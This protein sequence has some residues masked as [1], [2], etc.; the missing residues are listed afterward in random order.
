MENFK[1]VYR[2]EAGELLLEL[3]SSLLE[4]EKYPTDKELIGKVFRAMHTIKGSGA[5]FGFTDIAAFTHDLETVFDLVRND[6]MSVG[7]ELIGLVLAACDHIRSLLEAAFTEKPADGE[8]GK[9][10][11]DALRKL[12]PVIDKPPNLKSLDTLQKISDEPEQDSESNLATFRIFF[13]P[14]RNIF[15][16]GTNPLSLF[17]ELANFGKC[18]I[19]AHPEGIPALD[20]INPEECYTCWDIILTTS[21]D[22]NDIKDVFIFIEDMSELQV[23][24]LYNSGPLPDAA[25]HEIIPILKTTS[26]LASIFLKD[27][28]QKYQPVIST[29]P[30]SIILQKPEEKLQPA[31]TNSEKVKTTSIR[32]ASEKLDTLVDLVGEFVTVQARLAQFAHRTREIDAV[33]ISEQVEL[34]TSELRD[35]VMSLRML[36]IGTMF[37]KFRRLVRDLSVELGKDVE[38]LTAGEETELDKTL[39]EKLSDPLIHLIRN[40]VDHGI[41]SPQVRKQK[42]KPS[43]GIIRLEAVH[44]GANVFIKITDDG[45]GLDKNSIFAKAV[46]KGLVRNDAELS[47]TEI[48]DFIFLPGFSTSATVSNVSGRGVGMDVVGKAITSMN[49]SIQISSIPGQETAITLV[50]PLTL[51]IIDGLLARIDNEHFIFP[52]SAVEECI[53]LSDAIIENQNGRRTVNVRG[54]LV[55]YLRLRDHFNINGGKPAMEQ[56]VIASINAKQFGFAVDRVIGGHQTVIKSLGKVYKDIKGVSGATILG[57]GSVALILDLIKLEQE[58]V[59]LERNTYT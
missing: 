37:E 6:K 52:L 10:I 17:N 1:N 48:F 46:E 36:A 56:I 32:V 23:D 53:E 20:L 38:L 7:K 12:I 9:Q 54:K 4:L 11:T 2:E 50:L 55:P 22:I 51:A 13:R 47:E 26:G 30:A 35:N 18:Y 40:A 27:I 5:M 57:D 39:I 24:C 41:E 19:I 42:G 58:A 3:E 29:T 44:S 8:T 25:L 21:K 34:L 33:L 15:I 43:K 28:I 16:T 31:L 49:G 59:K 14:A 45:K